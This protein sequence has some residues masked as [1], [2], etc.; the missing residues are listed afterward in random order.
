[1]T[2]ARLYSTPR[3]NK[4]RNSFIYNHLWSTNL[5]LNLATFAHLPVPNSSATTHK[6]FITSLLLVCLVAGAVLLNEPSSADQAADYQRSLKAITREIANLSENLNANKKLLKSER[7]RLALTEQK[8]VQ[9]NRALVATESEIAASRAQATQI[10]QQ[11]TTLLRDQAADLQSL[12][13]LLKQRYQQGQPNYL[14]MVLNQENPYA[15][16]RLNNYYQYFAAAQKQKLSEI[17]NQLAAVE[18]LQADQQSNLEKLQQQQTK[19]AQQQQNLQTAKSKR[20]NTVAAL[21]AKVAETGTRLKRLQQDRK[22]LNNLLEQLA[23]Q[24]AKLKRIEEERLAAER[25]A[26]EE[27]KQRGE[28]APTP[29]V[30]MLL[31]GGF[32]KQ[33]GRLQAPVKGTRKYRFGSRLAESGMK[34]QG[35]FYTTTGAQPVTSIF[36]GRVLFADYL[37]GYGLLMIIDHGDDHISL[38]GHNELL[39]KTVGDMV[40]TGETVAR[41]GVSGGLQNPGL[42]FEIR[43][44]ATPVDPSKWLR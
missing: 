28:V 19:L 24:A 29:Q 14:K 36:R 30:R 44:S 23:I 43:R 25:R 10:E 42:Y 4:G 9:L 2:E 8:I 16:G 22:R 11:I 27:A 3:P 20:K 7:D 15:V 31:K 13:T 37:K 41:S 1:M 26:Q 33:Q 5:T 38:Y 34:S 39:Y 40:E 21:D 17:A 32:A 18:T 6:K 12:K 35:E